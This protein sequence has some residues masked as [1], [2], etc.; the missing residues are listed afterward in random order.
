MLMNPDS[1][2]KKEKKFDEYENAL[3]KG[4]LEALDCIN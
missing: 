3:E 2:L 1:Q 4:V